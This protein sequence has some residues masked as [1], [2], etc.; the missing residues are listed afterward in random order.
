MKKYS[1]GTN[2]ERCLN[3]FYDLVNFS[4]YN[5]MKK[6]SQGTNAERCLNV[7]YDFV[8]RDSSGCAVCVTPYSN[9]TSTRGQYDI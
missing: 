1:Q 6:Y 2:A 8:T 4:I 9:C 3:M 7:C 5:H